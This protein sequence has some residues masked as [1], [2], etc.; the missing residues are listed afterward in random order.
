VNNSAHSGGM[1]VLF[2]ED[3][4]NLLIFLTL[5]WVSPSP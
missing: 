2:T 1:A 3:P 5:P 4:P